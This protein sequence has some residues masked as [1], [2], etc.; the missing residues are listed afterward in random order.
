M[1]VTAD[2]QTP[3]EKAF[4]HPSLNFNVVPKG[5]PWQLK[6]S[7]MGSFIGFLL[8]LPKYIGTFWDQGT[9]VKP[10]RQRGLDQG[11]QRVTCGL[12]GCPLG[13]G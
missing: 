6:E 9:L 13:S 10:Q 2:T 5:V 1:A 12:L 11:T 7:L 4:F 8:P 3:T